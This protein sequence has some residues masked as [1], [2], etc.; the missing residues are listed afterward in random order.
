LLNRYRVSGVVRLTG[1]FTVESLSPH[2]VLSTDDE[3]PASEVA[4]KKEATTGQFET[5][6]VEN[7][8]K[9]GVQNTRRAERLQFDRLDAYFGTWLHAAGEYTENGKTKRVNS[10][11]GPEHG[12][13]S[14]EQIKEAAKEALKGAGFDLLIV[15]GFAFDAR[16]NE[17]AKEFTPMLPRRA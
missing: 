2:R 8:R 4:A 3:R 17:T 12:T 5:V 14:P 6:I 1:P 11:I 10:S 13:V 7:I 9:A 16:A 15:C